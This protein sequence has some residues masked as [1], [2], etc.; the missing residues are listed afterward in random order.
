M[1]KKSVVLENAESLSKIRTEKCLILLICLTANSSANYKLEDSFLHPL[2]I[3]NRIVNKIVP[4][5]LNYINFFFFANPHL[6]QN[7]ESGMII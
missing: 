4:H 2:P 6:L 1:R 5:V 3:A 7:G